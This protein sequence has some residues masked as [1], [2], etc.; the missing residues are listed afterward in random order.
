M[1]NAV[2]LFCLKYLESMC[3][4]AACTLYSEWNDWLASCLITLFSIVGTCFMVKQCLVFFIFRLS[5]T[6]CTKRTLPF[7]IIWR[8]PMLRVRA[9]GKQ[10]FCHCLVGN[11]IALAYLVTALVSGTFWIYYMFSWIKLLICRYKD[12]HTVKVEASVFDENKK[13]FRFAST[14][15]EETTTTPLLKAQY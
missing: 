5:F 15:N 9:Y 14:K 11:A 13:R 4:S 3:N 2:F 7:T 10:V 12:K 6:L 8:I 1:S